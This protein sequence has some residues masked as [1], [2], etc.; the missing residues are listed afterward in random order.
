MSPITSDVTNFIVG[1]P[2]E[3]LI[4][5]ELLNKCVSRTVMD[6]T[7]PF[8]YQ[9]PT[10]NGPLPFRESLSRFLRDSGRFPRKIQAE[11]ICTSFGN[12]SAISL[13]IQSLSIPGQSVIVEDPTYFLIG[14]VLRN[15]HLNIL[16]CRVNEESGLNVDALRALLSA[17]RPRFVYVNPIH[18]NPTGSCM[19]VADREQLIQLSHAYDFIIL[20][21]EPY[22][23]L[24]FNNSSSSIPEEYTSLG[25]TASRMGGSDYKNLLCFGSFSKILTPGLRCGW[26]TGHP[27]LIKK[28]TLH[29]SLQSGGGPAPIIIE[30]IRSMIENGQLNNHIDSL[31]TWLHARATRMI[32]SIEKYFGPSHVAY[33]VPAGG[34]FVLLRFLDSR[35]DTRD[36][37]KYLDSNGISIK[38]LPGSRCRAIREDNTPAN[39]RKQ[40]RLAFSF[41]TPDE[42]EMGIE[43]LSIGYFA[44]LSSL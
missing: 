21:D 39:L 6:N 44:Y 8:I 20:S 2:G 16:T 33:H 24:P 40:L 14:D 9:Y 12:S 42:I 13:A 1:Q 28:I 18:Q 38:F 27:D 31:R 22:V 15:A 37:Q 25:V 32:E 23:L 19:P 3:A 26:I 36:F 5:F 30:T 7:D 29:G 41:Y 4:P 11:S 10:P 34:Y 17:H 35:V 43:K